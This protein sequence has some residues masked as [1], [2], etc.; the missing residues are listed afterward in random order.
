MRGGSTDRV[1]FS[2]FLAYF[3]EAQPEAVRKRG[4]LAFLQDAGADP[5]WRCAPGVVAQTCPGLN[6]R[7]STRGR[8]TEIVFETPVG[9]IRERYTA[10]ERGNTNY[11]TQHPLRARHDYEVLAWIEEHTVLTYDPRRADDHLAGEGR[12]GLSL[13]NPLHERLGGGIKSAFQH[14]VEHWVGTQ[15]LAYTLFDEPELVDL[16]LEPMRRRNLEAVAISAERAPYE[17]YLTWED[18][19]TQNYS[20]QMYER[21]IAGE[22]SE[23]QSILAANEKTYV[24]H[25][26]GHLRAILPAMRDQG[27][28]GVESLTPPETGNVGVAEAR[29]LVGSNFGII[30]GIEPILLEKLSAAELPDYVERVIEENA[31]GRFILANADSCPPGVA[32]EK[33]AAIA[34]HLR[35]R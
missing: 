20:P 26:C 2:P 16:V 28:W 9:S 22:I 17:F 34:E 21:Y 4:Q 1:P 29:A 23:W 10:S 5:L 19:S 35:Q 15:Q 24:Q 27:I 33:F 11:L 30:G 32:P 3:W 7:E 14:L 25:A 12:E 6:R 31:G 13:G 8:E 18:S